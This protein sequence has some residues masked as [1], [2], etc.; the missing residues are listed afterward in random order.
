MREKILLTRCNF[1]N[2]NRVLN[3][4][5]EDI[6]FRFDEA[7]NKISNFLNVKFDDIDLI[8]ES[9]NVNKSK[10]NI[11]LWKNYDKQSEIDFINKELADYMKFFNYE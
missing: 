11:G 5:F 1:N 6:V 2:S 4:K 7:V 8:K 9:I 3:L 10:S